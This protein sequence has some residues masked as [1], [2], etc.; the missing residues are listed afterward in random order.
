MPQRCHRHGQSRHRIGIHRFP[1]RRTHTPKGVSPS[2]LRQVKGERQH[3]STRRTRR[4]AVILPL[5]PG[6]GVSLYVP[7]PPAQGRGRG[8][9]GRMH[10]H[11]RMGAEIRCK[12]KSDLQQAQAA[13]P[14]VPGSRGNPWPFCHKY[15][16]ARRDQYHPHQTC[17][18]WVFWRLQGS[19]GHQDD[20]CTKRVV[21]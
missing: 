11:L 7:G 6:A 1:L 5:A 16:G 13:H 17:A 15:H 12:R 3:G 4:G 8:A 14:G 19:R 2:V 9:G 18:S 10:S 21:P 20:V